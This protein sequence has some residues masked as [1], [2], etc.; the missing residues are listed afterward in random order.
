[1]SLVLSWLL[2]ILAPG[3]VIFEIPPYFQEKGILSETGFSFFGPCISFTDYRGS[4]FYQNACLKEL[5]ICHNHKTYL[6]NENF[7]VTPHRGP[8]PP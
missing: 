3:F 2:L 5:V 1:M 6:P 7:K 4:F 8:L